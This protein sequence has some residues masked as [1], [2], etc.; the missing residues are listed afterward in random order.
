[1]II[2]LLLIST[3]GSHSTYGSG[4]TWFSQVKGGNINLKKEWKRFSQVKGGNINFKERKWKWFNQVK[5]GNENFKERVKLKVNI[6]STF[7]IFKYYIINEYYINSKS[8]SEYYF[9]V[10][11]ISL[12]SESEHHFNDRYI[13]EYYINLKSDRSSL[14]VRERSASDKW[15]NKLKREKLQR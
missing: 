10:F 5:G 2:L 4:F 12:K 9:N 1:M 14:V 3:S 7:T 11:Y 15:Q 6:I 13:F 8:E